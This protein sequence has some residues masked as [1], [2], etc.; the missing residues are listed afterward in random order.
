M[1]FSTLCTAS[2]RIFSSTDS[3]VYLSTHYNAGTA[4]STVADPSPSSDGQTDNDD[5][6]A[7]VVLTLSEVKT[8][9]TSPLLPTGTM[10]SWDMQVLPPIIPTPSFTAS[11]SVA[12]LSLAVTATG[13]SIPSVQLVT[14]PAHVDDTSAPASALDPYGY[15]STSS[16][17]SHSK[18]PIA[19][20]VTFISIAL[21]ASIGFLL[22]RRCGGAGARRRNG[23][24]S[25]D[26]NPRYSCRTQQWASLQSGNTSAGAAG[27]VQQSRDADGDNDDRSSSY[28]DSVIGNSDQTDADLHRSRSHQA[29]SNTAEIVI[30]EVPEEP[31]QS[32]PAVG[33]ERS[34]VDHKMTA[35]VD[36][37]GFLNVAISTQGHGDSGKSFSSVV[38]SSM[39]RSVRSV[40]TTGKRF[41][42][43]FA[44]KPENMP[45]HGDSAS[46]VSVSVQTSNALAMSTMGF[47]TNYSDAHHTDTLQRESDTV[48]PASDVLKCTPNPEE[49]EPG[50]C[51]HEATSPK[52]NTENRQNR[53]GSEPAQHGTPSKS[54]E[55]RTPTLR[56][57][58]S[59]RD[60]F[61]PTPTQD[62]SA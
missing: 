28:S 40:S 47:T 11:T 23:D 59:L 45:M 57:A 43:V 48:R 62:S 18:L 42:S 5:P 1:A 7:S 31:R 49:E 10:H 35:P 37:F 30:S 13:A 36:R 60:I 15:L 16:K 26:P 4:T 44:S 55:V 27:G 51:G 53:S 33:P 19:L 8:L 54:P 52:A 3:F 39:Q 46:A 41:S 22:H 58:V 6:P 17:S 9:T 50:T 2:P 21:I 25:D 24:N 61:S 56:S 32:H 14:V 20:S 38:F 34:N 12:A 29:Q